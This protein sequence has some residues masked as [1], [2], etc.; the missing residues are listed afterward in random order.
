MRLP[1]G[2]N[3]MPKNRPVGML[4]E[5]VSCP[6][7]A[8]HTCRWPQKGECADPAPTSRRE[9]WLPKTMRLPSGENA[10]VWTPVGSRSSLAGRMARRASTTL[11]RRT[12][13]RTLTPR[14]STT[15]RP[16]IT[17]RRLETGGGTSGEAG[18]GWVRLTIGRSSSGRLRRPLDDIHYFLLDKQRGQSVREY[19]FELPPSP[20]GAILSGGATPC[21]PHD[22]ASLAADNPRCSHAN[23]SLRDLPFRSCCSRPRRGRC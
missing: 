3:A 22:P 9:A 4:R 15:R 18:G 6:V 20:R 12:T 23:H 1:S 2:E 19:P 5:C 16:T 7:C 17:L 10:T 14:N 13:H 21:P 8:S 11:G